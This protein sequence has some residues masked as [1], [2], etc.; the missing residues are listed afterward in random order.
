[1]SFSSD[2]E[3]FVCWRVSS[4]EQAWE[5]VG[6]TEGGEAKEETKD[7][8]HKRG[9]DEISTNI[10]KTVIIQVPRRDLQRRIIIKDYI[11]SFSPKTFLL[12]E[13]KFLLRVL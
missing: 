1:M 11:L 9:R 5:W 12:C 7:V 10:L 13:S 4:P 2:R 8:L 6:G 3:T